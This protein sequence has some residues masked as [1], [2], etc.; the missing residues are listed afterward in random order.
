MIFSVRHEAFLQVIVQCVPWVMANMVK[1]TSNCLHV[2]PA[3]NANAGLTDGMGA[4]QSYILT[5]GEA[6]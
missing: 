6:R 2:C 3:T 5:I 1:S 4:V